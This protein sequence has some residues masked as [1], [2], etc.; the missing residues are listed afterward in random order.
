MYVSDCTF[1]LSL[2]KWSFLVLWRVQYNVHCAMFISV[3]GIVRT[4]TMYSIV[5]YPYYVVLSNVFYFTLLYLLC[6]CILTVTVCLLCTLPCAYLVL[7]YVLT[8]YF[9]MYLLLYF[10][11]IL[12]VL[13][14]V[15][16]RGILE[17]ERGRREHEVKDDSSVCR[18]VRVRPEKRLPAITRPI[19]PLEEQW[20]IQESMRVIEKIG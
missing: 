17:A 20:T 6:T 4:C 10:A 11:M 1:T 5:N 16:G 19:E 13:W 18:L 2:L 3:L 12:L 8:M 14:H 7:Y 9:T 15:C